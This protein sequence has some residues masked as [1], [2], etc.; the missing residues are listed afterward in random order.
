MKPAH[1]LRLFA[2]AA[3]LLLAGCATAPGQDNTATLIARPDF[4]DAVK[5]APLFVNECLLTITR[6]E[7]QLQT[8]RKAK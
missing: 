6:L 1:S 2:I 3:I 8:T 4:K 7:E 5:A